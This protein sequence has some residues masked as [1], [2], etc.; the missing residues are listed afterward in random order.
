MKNQL[1]ELQIVVPV[2]LIRASANAS[3][4]IARCAVDNPAV[5]ARFIDILL[6]A[7]S[8]SGRK[9]GR[10]TVVPRG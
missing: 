2:T 4:E 9:I 7:T 6:N 10:V 3:G 8:H 1:T 5:V